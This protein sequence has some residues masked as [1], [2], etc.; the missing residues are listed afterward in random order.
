VPTRIIANGA[1][2]VDALTI[3]AANT[4]IN[5]A[6][7]DVSSPNSGPWN[8]NQVYNL[9][10]GGLIYSVTLQVEQEATAGIICNGTPAD[11]C[12]QTGSASIDP[13]IMID[14]SFANNGLYS[15]E[16]SPGIGSGVAAVPGPVAGAGLPGLIAACGGLLGW[17]R[18]R[19]KIA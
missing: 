6:T 12:L 18:R 9:A 5:G 13:I 3:H 16:F 11:A 10:A 1:G 2:F 7:Y 4:G 14:S 19:K 17:W 15:I 8:I